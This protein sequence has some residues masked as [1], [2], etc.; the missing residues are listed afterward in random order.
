MGLLLL[1]YREQLDL[2]TKLKWPALDSESVPWALHTPL[3]SLYEWSAIGPLCNQISSLPVNSI[4]QSQ[5]PVDVGMDGRS[6][7][8]REEAEGAREDGELPSLVSFASS[9]NDIKLN[10]N[11]GPNLEHS[12]QLTLISKSTISPLGKSQS[13]KKYDDSDLMLDIDCDL[14]EPAPSEVEI[15]NAGS[16][17][18][19]ERAD[20]S[21][22]DYGVREYY[23][24]LSRKM[25]AK[26]KDVKL[27]AKV[28]LVLSLTSYSDHSLTTW[29]F[30]I[31][32]LWQIKISREYPLR[33]PL[34]A[35]SLHACSEEDYDDSNNSG[36][37]NE[38]RSMEA[39]VIHR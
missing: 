27:K 6:G 33:P 17:E 29:N 21:W 30:D 31:A 39:E 10:P 13:F 9:A 19:H 37:Y 26:E 24:T 35:L 1:N 2:L 22:M 20:N 8:S 16:G 12:R 23:L 38:L 28:V 32:S 34:L 3:C 14:D 25:D 5:E 7:P 18:F 36:G 4:E 11:K 15:E